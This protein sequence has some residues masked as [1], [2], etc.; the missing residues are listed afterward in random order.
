MASLNITVNDAVVARVRQAYGVDTNAE[1]KAVIVSEIKNKVIDFE[2]LQLR[3]SESDTFE[4]NLK[5]TLDN[6]RTTLDN[7]IQ[8]S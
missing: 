7:D 5:T 2:L 6:T 1:L 8:V 3:K 4:A